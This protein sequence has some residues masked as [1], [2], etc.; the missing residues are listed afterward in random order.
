MEKS[1]PADWRRRLQGEI[2][3]VPG[4]RF[5]SLRHPLPPRLSHLHGRKLLFLSDLHARDAGPTPSDSEHPWVNCGFPAESVFAVL[6][7]FQPHHLLFGGDLIRHISCFD[8]AVSFLKQLPCASKIG[9]YGNW[10]KKRADWFPYQIFERAYQQASIPILCNEALVIDGIRFYGLD[11]FKTGI[12]EYSGD[13][14]PS[15]FHCVLSHNPDA[16]PAGMSE[17]ELRETDLILCGHTHGGQVC[18][19]VYGALL[20]SSIYGKRFEYGFYRNSRTQTPM[21]ITS[22]LGT[23]FLPFRFHCPPEVVGIELI[24]DASDQSGT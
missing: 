5:V 20:T 16:V 19:P 11:D 14:D 7:F 2:K 23:T 22:G 15:L 10:D 6:D 8:A 12:P 17:S 4:L 3:Y 1:S 13:P 21:F 9:V 24:A 18:L